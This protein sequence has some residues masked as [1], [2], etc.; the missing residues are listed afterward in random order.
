MIYFVTYDSATGKITARHG[1]T[2]PIQ[3]K[4]YP[5]A[6]E[7]TREQWTQPLEVTSK[8][9][10]ETGQIVPVDENATTKVP[11]KNS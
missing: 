7:I 11:L 8:I 6:V 4:Y 10:L 5:H 3:L 1:A 9:D 2:D